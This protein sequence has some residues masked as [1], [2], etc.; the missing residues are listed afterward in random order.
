MQAAGGQDYPLESGAGCLPLTA[1]SVQPG[2]DNVRS[3]TG[4][5]GSGAAI[6]CPAVGADDGPE[7]GAVGIFAG[8][9]K[10]KR[11]QLLLTKAVRLSSCAPMG[12]RAPSLHV[13]YGRRH[14]A[15][16]H[17]VV[18]RDAAVVAGLIGPKGEQLGGYSSVPDFGQSFPRSLRS[19]FGI[20]V[21]EIACNRGVPRFCLG[22]LECGCH[23]PHFSPRRC[24]CWSPFA[25]VLAQ[26]NLAAMAANVLSVP[27]DRE[28]MPCTP[29]E[30]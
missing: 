24:S 3:D 12:A 13:H 30:K 28:Y 20:R 29:S 10:C 22:G 27:Y 18:E 25:R 1:R 15:A 2:S 23:K 21:N 8:T 5:G 11:G 26:V 6:C 14:A 7:F 17:L 9:A 19:T 16:D 4:F